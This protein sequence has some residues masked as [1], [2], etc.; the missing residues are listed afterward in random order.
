MQEREALALGCNCHNLLGSVSPLHATS[1]GSGS[2]FPFSIHVD[3]LGP[4]STSS[5]EQLKVTL[6][7]LSAAPLV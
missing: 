3:E 5:E 7:P 2:H 1:L 4:V 6:S